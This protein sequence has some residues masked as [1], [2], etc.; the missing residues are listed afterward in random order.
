VQ[1]ELRH[2]SGSELAWV[3]GAC[4]AQVRTGFCRI[5]GSIVNKISDKTFGKLRIARAYVKLLCMTEGSSK[6][7]VSLALIGTSEIRLFEGPQTSSNGKP[8]FY[9]ELFD[10]GANMS[11]DSF[12]CHKIDDAVVIFEDFIS[13]A[14]RLTEASGPDGA[15]TQS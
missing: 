5:Q 1:I 6:A 9:L 3:D 15:E 12:G 7:S 8:L 10:H 2:F 13:Q 11:V 4:S 14:G